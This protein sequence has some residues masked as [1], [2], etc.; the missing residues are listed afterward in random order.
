MVDRPSFIA[1]CCCKGIVTSISCGSGKWTMA[2]DQSTAGH[3]SLAAAIQDA[4]CLLSGR[5]GVMSIR[6]GRVRVGCMTL[7]DPDLPFD[8]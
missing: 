4:V 8:Q 1:A 2:C 3:A 5:V 6:G 7:F